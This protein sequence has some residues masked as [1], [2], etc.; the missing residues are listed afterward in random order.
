MVRVGV[1]TFCMDWREGERRKGRGGE[2][3][4]TGEGKGNV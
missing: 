3:G 1:L 2:K 4:L